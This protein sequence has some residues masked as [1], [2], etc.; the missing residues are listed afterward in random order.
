[1]E[2]KTIQEQAAV[3]AEKNSHVRAA[4]EKLMKKWAEISACGEIVLSTTATTEK[5]LGVNLFLMAGENDL[6]WE[7]G[8]SGIRE[9]TDDAY[10][11][12]ERGGMNMRDLRDFLKLFPVM[13][14]E[15][16]EKMKEKENI[17][18]D[19]IASIEKMLK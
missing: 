18:D 11:W 3:L 16:L 1:M 9:Y 5:Y 12:N 17:C 4:T 15:I 6:Q 14:D 8:D 10:C 7:N 19:R 13:A 2:I